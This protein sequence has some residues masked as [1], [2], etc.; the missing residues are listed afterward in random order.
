MESSEIIVGL[1]IGTTKIAC[2]VGRKNEHG[3][4]EILGMGTSDS[5]GVTRGVVSNIEKTVD[6]ILKAVKEAE[7]ESGIE[8]T[9]VNVGIAGQ[10]IR[11]L[12]HRGMLTRESLET[13]IGQKDIDM[14]INDMYRL[15]MQPGE[16]IITVLPQE[17]IVDYEQGI[18]HPIGMSGIRLEANFHIIVGQVSA[19]KNIYKCVNRANLEVTGLH[20]E[21]LASSAAVL[22]DE[23]KDAG[24]V[25]VDIGGGTTDVAIFQE[26]IIRHTA[27]IPFG[28]DAITRDIKTGLSILEKQAEL[29]KVKFGSAIEHASQDNEIV[30]IP[31]FK[32]RQPKEISLRNLAR[33]INPRMAEIIDYINYNIKSSGFDKQLIAGIVVTGGGSQLKHLPQ[34]FEYLTGMD[35]RIGY[36]NEHISSNGKI[37][38]TSPKYATGVGLV[39]TGVDDADKELRRN[40]KVKQASAKKNNNFLN[41]ILGKVSDYLDEEHD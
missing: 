29:L 38:V 14:L 41:R 17:Y 21:P 35:A 34:L 11:S 12:Q 27:V 5:I 36:P 25:L 19:I 18:K 10:H 1:D 23:E 9:H 4:I 31:G 30:C 3:K 2:L 22:S 16:E 40:A 8:I 33:I 13:E 20:L 37:T 32:N 26:G 28:G 15:V 7:R 6:S 39:F 24:V